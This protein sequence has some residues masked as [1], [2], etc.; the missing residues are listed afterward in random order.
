[1]NRIWF[2]GL[3]LAGTMLASPTWLWGQSPAKQPTPAKAAAASPTPAKPASVEKPAEGAAANKA[4]TESAAAEPQ[5]Y[6]LR[7]KFRPGEEI[8]WKTE[9]RS[10]IRSTVQ[11]VSATAESFSESVKVWKVSAVDAEGNMTFEHSFASIKMRQKHSGKAE[12]SFDSL[13]DDKPLPIFEETAKTVGIPLAEVTMDPRGK[14][15]RRESKHKSSRDQG[16]M[17]MTLPENPVKVGEEWTEP[18]DY[19]VTAPDG[20]RRPIRA[21]QVYRLKAVEHGI[22][23]IELETQILTPVNEPSVQAQLVQQETKGDVRFDIERGRIVGQQFDLDKPIV[24][25]KGEGSSMHCRT[26]YREELLP[27][28]ESTARKE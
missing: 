15:V 27:E 25:F 1:M 3:V 10:H 17:T 26:R 20:T 14:V 13:T 21:R 7:Y 28:V 24:N 9:H 16:Q 5:P 11:G 12:L 2:A 19:Q 18:L 4:A 22:A 6:T 23:L 8:R